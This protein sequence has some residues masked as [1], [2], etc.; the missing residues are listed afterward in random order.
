MLTDW[1]AYVIRMLLALAIG[2]G[3]GLWIYRRYYMQPID[4]V[5]RNLR[6]IEEFSQE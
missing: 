2:I 6:E 4:E 3:L 1:K 5:T